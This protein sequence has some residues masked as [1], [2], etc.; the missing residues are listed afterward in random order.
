MWDKVRPEDRY[1]RNADA[2][3]SAHACKSGRWIRLRGNARITNVSTQFLNEP[4]L[5]LPE[6][7]D[8]LLHFNFMWVYT[9]ANNST[10]GEP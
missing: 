4:G 5:V 7:V 6:V 1:S 2:S 8:Y 3:H 9:D 10:L